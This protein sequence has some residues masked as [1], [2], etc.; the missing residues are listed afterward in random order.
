VNAH[1]LI[2]TNTAQPQNQLIFNSDGYYK[3]T[4][5]TNE[6]NSP[7][8]GAVLTNNFTTANNA[9]DNGVALSGYTRTANLT[10]AASYAHAALTYN[11]TGVG[12]PT[13]ETGA[14]VDDLETL[15]IVFNAGTHSRGVK[16]VTI[17][18]N[19]GNS[20]LGSNQVVG[21]WSGVVS[22]VNYSV[23]DISG[24]LIGQFASFAEGAITIPTIYSNIG[25]I[26]IEASSP[27]QARIQSMTFQS[28]TGSGTSAE[29]APEVIGY[30]LVDADGDSSQATLSL[31][32]I[33]DHFAGNSSANIING[34]ST[35]DMISGLA[36]NDTLNGGAG[37]DVIYGGD[38]NDIINGDAG[39]DRLS[40]NAGDDT[41][42][43]GTGNDRIYGDE[44]NDSL[45]G[46][47]GNDLIYGG[48]GND[49]I[50]GG[51][52]AD[53]IYGAAGNDTLAGGDTGLVDVFKWELGDQG[54]KGAPASDVIQ[55]WD[56]ADA[57][58]LTSV[59]GDVLDL[60]DLLQGE[61]SP[62]NLDDFLHFE[63]SGGN[64]IVHIS[65]TGEFATGYNPAKEVQAITLLNTDLFGAGALNTDQQ[66]IQDMLNKGKLITD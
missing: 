64:T 47:D 65:A 53:I 55:D 12:I 44:G 38:G 19:A 4:P 21:A 9:D 11:G 52:G 16:N 50:Q 3:Y 1:S 39:D 25:R 57:N 63:L 13:G 45:T 7:T 46:G 27:A 32:A 22:S 30:T 18:V 40:G 36:G 59:G 54:S 5:L 62:G 42:S 35:N 61:H 8:L 33:S 17:N 41:I 15:V 10:Q 24:N 2:W 43:G 48:A 29:I 20:N 6:I 14:A 28:I 66:I 58:V 31:N 51:I 26:E 60:R 34:A 49:T 37:H 56:N 23:F